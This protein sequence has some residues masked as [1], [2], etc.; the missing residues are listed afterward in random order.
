MKAKAEIK[1]IQIRVLVGSDD[2]RVLLLAPTEGKKEP[3][4]IQLLPSARIRFQKKKK[5]KKKSSIGI[6]LHV[7]IKLHISTQTTAART[8]RRKIL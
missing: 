8:T 1:Q 3:S 7:S 2:F 4:W 6:L 5:R